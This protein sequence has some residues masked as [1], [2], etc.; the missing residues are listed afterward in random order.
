MKLSR[1]KN[2]FNPL[3]KAQ[4]QRQLRVAELINAS[5]VACLR[6]G[7]GLDSRLYEMPLSITKVI[8]SADLRVASCYFIPFNTTLK[9]TELEQALEKS[10]YHIR[11]YVTAQI[12]LKYSPEIRFFYDETFENVARIDQLFDLINKK[13]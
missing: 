3:I 5:I 13:V 9:L 8:V 10:K 12:K 4:S 2:T 1:S 7:K 6:N 11:G